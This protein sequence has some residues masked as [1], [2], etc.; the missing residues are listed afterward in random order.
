LGSKA[1]VGLV[2]LL[3]GGLLAVLGITLREIGSFS[4]RRIDFP[5]L[6]Q[7]DAA[8]AVAQERLKVNPQDLESLVELGKLHFEKGKDAYPEA[9][10]ELEEAREMGALDARI[11]Y[12]L[13]VMY[14]E[15]GLAPFA[16]EEYRR[17]LRHYPNDKEVRMFLA[18]LLY[19]L[20]RFPQAVSEYE[21][22]K[23]HFPHD[24]L[25]AE[26]LALSLWGA[27]AIDR[28]A[29][30]FLELVSRGPQEARRAEFH[31]G[32]IR[33]EQGRFQ[34]ALDHLLRSHPE[35]GPLGPG[36]PSEKLWETLAMSHQKLGRLEEA[37]E[38]WEKVLQASPAKPQARAALR[39]ISRRLS[40][41]RT[42]KKRK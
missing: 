2:V 11:F 5:P 10:N 19:A 33:S 15:V 35:Q 27:K 30:Q 34:E 7:L 31:L 39:D 29:Q 4:R 3:V 28:A 42:A 18:K 13:G 23:F 12:C 24:N 8:I 17:Y 21:R 40:A 41:K 25:I 6:P 22:L 9:I 26:N 32:M 14:Q 37:R 20:K 36:I 16:I 38:A 1:V